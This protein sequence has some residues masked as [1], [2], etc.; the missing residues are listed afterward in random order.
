MGREKRPAGLV[1]SA[2]IIEVEKLKDFEFVPLDTI[3][4]D[5]LVDDALRQ[6]LQRYLEEYEHDAFGVYVGDTEQGKVHALST[7]DE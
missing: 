2:D 6:L 3:P 7:A 1:D 5:D 4:W